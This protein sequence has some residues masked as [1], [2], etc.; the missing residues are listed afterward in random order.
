MRHEA[1]CAFDTTELPADPYIA[2]H[3]LHPLDQ[4]KVALEISEVLK[5][6]ETN[7]LADF[8]SVA[9]PDTRNVGLRLGSSEVGPT[10]SLV[11]DAWDEKGPIADIRIVINAQTGTV[12]SHDLQK[13]VNRP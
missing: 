5:I 10:W 11:G 13:G 9:P 3:A 8:C 12:V 4:S 2:S 7:G 6:V 1:F